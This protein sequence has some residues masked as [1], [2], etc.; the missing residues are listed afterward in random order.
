MKTPATEDFPEI[1]WAITATEL[2][3]ESVHDYT[4][5]AIGS[6]VKGN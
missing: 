4:L 5:L 6:D 2:S 1:E 3:R